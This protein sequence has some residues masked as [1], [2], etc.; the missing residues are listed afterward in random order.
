MLRLQSQGF[1]FAPV[2]NVLGDLAHSM[3]ISSAELKPYLDDL[4]VYQDMPKGMTAGVHIA[5]FVLKPRIGGFEVLVRKDLRNLLPSVRLSTGKL[6][7]WHTAFLAAYDDWDVHSLLN[8]WKLERNLNKFPPDQKEF[9]VELCNAMRQLQ[10]RIGDKLFQHG[11]LIARPFQGPCRSSSRDKDTEKVSHQSATVIAFRFMADIHY[12]HPAVDQ[13]TFVPTR[14]FLAQQHCYAGSPDHHVFASHVREEFAFLYEAADLYS[15]EQGQGSTFKFDQKVP[16]RKPSFLRKSTKTKTRN[17]IAASPQPLSSK[18][19]DVTLA[20]TAAG[21]PKLS[22]AGQ[23]QNHDRKNSNYNH[24]AKSPLMPNA[25]EPPSGGI[26]VSSQIEVKISEASPSSRASSP[27]MEKV[28]TGNGKGEGIEMN[29]IGGLPCGVR[30]EIGTGRIIER[31]SMM[32][33]LMG[34]TLGKASSPEQRQAAG[35]GLSQGVEEGTGGW[36]WGRGSA[37]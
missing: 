12:I 18:N 14:I 3:Q 16:S 27:T 13:D 30:T 20:S 34:L 25:A 2:N 6:D 17:C 19:S 35:L 21:S 24:N 33:M 36:T 8:H 9:V 29:E 10:S 23:K 31:E 37:L 1:S 15:P 4:S 5:S 26:H 32:D 28:I 22:N 11:R 7:R